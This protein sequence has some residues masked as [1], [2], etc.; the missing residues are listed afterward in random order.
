MHVASLPPTVTDQSRRDFGYDAKLSLAAT[1]RIA[2]RLRRL[3]PANASNRGILV[4]V[5]VVAA[6]DAGRAI[7][8][9][10]ERLGVDAIS[11][12][13]GSRSEISRTLLGSVTRTVRASTRRPLLVVPAPLI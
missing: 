6:A 10:A 4:Q 3:V 13:S 2:D 5:E 12:G 7:S 9:A 8:Q 1:R 11:L